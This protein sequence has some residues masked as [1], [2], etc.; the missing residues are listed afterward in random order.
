MVIKNYTQADSR[1]RD[2]LDSISWGYTKNLTAIMNNQGS[3]ILNF[4]PMPI[5]SAISFLIKYN[6]SDTFNKWLEA[7]KSHPRQKLREKGSDY[8]ISLHSWQN[9]IQGPSS[10]QVFLPRRIQKYSYSFIHEILEET[11]DNDECGMLKL[12]A[13]LLKKAS[14]ILHQQTK[15]NRSSHLN[16]SAKKWLSVVTDTATSNLI[17][18]GLGEDSFQEIK[19]WKEA[20]S[21]TSVQRSG[22]SHPFLDIGTLFLH[23]ADIVYHSYK[24]HDF[25][26][27]ATDSE[28]AHKRICQD[29]EEWIQCCQKAI[30]QLLDPDSGDLMALYS[31][32]Y[33]YHMYQ[34]TPKN[35][36]NEKIP[37]PPVMEI[38]QGHW[39]HAMNDINKKLYRYIGYTPPPEEVEGYEWLEQLQT[40]MNV[41]I[42]SKK[43]RITNNQKD[44]R[45]TR[46]NTQHDIDCK[47]PKVWEDDRYVLGDMSL[48]T[49]FLKLDEYTSPNLDQDQWMKE[50]DL[51]E[52]RRV[53]TRQS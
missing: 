26:G 9:L 22:E 46:E 5:F 18:K 50:N 40:D 52:V 37:H 14:E 3:D 33:R 36:T 30:D 31:P 53:R 42:R 21:D 1:L 29:F 51:M 49:L 7:C 4:R 25:S 13:M 48:S 32:L 12:H 8:L 16:K 28:L 11:K 2:I 27:D 44:R 41:L 19:K 6:L 34:I 45:R 24:N 23:I 39:M 43:K 10:N 38:H 15:L 17:K 35:L 20:I 47:I